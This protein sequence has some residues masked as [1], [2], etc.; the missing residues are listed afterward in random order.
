M[1]IKNYKK[2]L[3]DKKLSFYLESFGAV[4]IEGPKW[5]GKTW[6]GRNASNSEFL[7]ASSY[8]NF[9]NKNLALM[10]PSLV[11]EGENPRL[12][13]EWQEVPS[14]WDAVR[15]A[16]DEKDKKGLFILTGSASINKNSY[17]HTG[18]G[19]IARLRMRPMSLYESSKSDGKISLLDICLGKAKDCITGEVDLNDLIEYILTGGWPSTIDLDFSHS[20]LVAK[21]YVKSIINEDIYKV[22]NVKRDKFKIELLLKSLARNEATT[23]TNATLKKILS[24]EI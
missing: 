22:D 17:I 19:R 3:I 21:E 4:L 12:L 23:A 5:C 18:T 20:I 2:R 24:I 7:L 16:V 1:K 6:T 10:N 8:S 9:N 11:L 14:L 13:D 15:W